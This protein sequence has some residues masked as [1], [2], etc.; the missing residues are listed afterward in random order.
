MNQASAKEGSLHYL[1][2]GCPVEFSVTVIFHI[3]VSNTV[4]TVATEHLRCGLCDQ[5]TNF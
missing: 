1:A 3:C 2:Q 4:V 5:V